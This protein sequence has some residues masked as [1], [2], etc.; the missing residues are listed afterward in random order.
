MKSQRFLLSLFY[1]VTA[2]YEQ[3]L[4]LKARF[5]YELWPTQILLCRYAW[6]YK[7]K[8]LGLLGQPY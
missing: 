8:F 3:N 6:Y 4:K 7:I 1:L 2:V 5:I